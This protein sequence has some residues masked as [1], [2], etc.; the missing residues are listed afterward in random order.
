[1]GMWVIVVMCVCVCQSALARECLVIFHDCR[2]R[3]RARVVGCS[4]G[5][6]KRIAL[7]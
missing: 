4:F 2:D 7:V 1:M 3:D 5:G 6:L